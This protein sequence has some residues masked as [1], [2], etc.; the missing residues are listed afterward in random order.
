MDAVDGPAGK[1]SSEIGPVMVRG[2]TPVPSACEIGS[3]SRPTNAPAGPP[4]E[5]PAD[6][7][8]PD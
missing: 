1:G 5:M 2:I 6:G 4:G 7:H 8:E 3:L